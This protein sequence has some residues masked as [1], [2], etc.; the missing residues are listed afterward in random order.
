MARESQGKAEAARLAA[1]QASRLAEQARQGVQEMREMR[2][3]REGQ[4]EAKGEPRYK[5]TIVMPQRS[6]SDEGPPL[7]KIL[8]V[9]GKAGIYPG[10][11]GPAGSGTHRRVQ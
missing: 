7:P 6:W 4:G 11:V 5:I 8:V 2:E 9:T 1:E 3:A 10:K